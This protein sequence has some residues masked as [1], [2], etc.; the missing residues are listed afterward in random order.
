MKIFDGQWKNEKGE[1]VGWENRVNFVD[2]FGVFVGYEYDKQ[3]CED[4]RWW[5]SESDDINELKEEKYIPENVN[6]DDYH[7]DD[8]FC[9]R[10][11]SSE[12]RD[13][14][15]CIFMLIPSPHSESRNVLYLHLYN[16]HNGYYHH[17]FEMVD[18][19]V[20]VQ[21]GNL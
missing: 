11:F 14:R 6:L 5:I 15:I 21:K 2:Q 10:G 7:F 4:F 20:I 16:D 3:C 18:E 13:I 12:D 9:I 19:D 1:L 8:N 17:G